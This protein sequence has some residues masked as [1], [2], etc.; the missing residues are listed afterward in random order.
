MWCLT[1]F[2]QL[3]KC[4]CRCRHS[5][6]Q[7]VLPIIQPDLPSR[8]I[9]KIRNRHLW[10]KAC[11]FS[12]KSNLAVADM[13]VGLLPGIVLMVDY[14]PVRCGFFFFYFANSSID[15]SLKNWVFR[16]TITALWVLLAMVLSMTVLGYHSGSPEVLVLFGPIPMYYFFM[17]VHCYLSFVHLY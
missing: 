6:A 3:N 8:P 1:R 17:A 12:S 14:N 11:S 7:P 5:S 9:E 15:A 2:Y 13:L 4:R 16:V 10:N